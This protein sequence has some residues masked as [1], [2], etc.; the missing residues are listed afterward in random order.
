MLPD[1]PPFEKLELVV[2]REKR[3]SRPAVVGSVLV[4]LVNFRRGDAVEGWFP[5]LNG[6]QASSTQA[7]EMRLK[8]RVDEWVDIVAPW[9]MR[10]SCG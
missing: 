7:G 5:V 10:G 2:C 1:L 8:I 3:L 6:G 4:V 9:L